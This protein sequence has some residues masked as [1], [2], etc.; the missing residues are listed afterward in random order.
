MVSKHISLAGP[1]ATKVGTDLPLAVAAVMDSS[2]QLTAWCLPQVSSQPK[3]ICLWRGFINKGPGEVTEFDM[4]VGCQFH[5]MLQQTVQ[6]GRTL[7]RSLILTI[8]V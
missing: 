3:V 8:H 7:T 4:Q 1:D 2:G 6:H 5:S